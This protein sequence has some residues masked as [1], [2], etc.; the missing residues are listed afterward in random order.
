[1]DVLCHLTSVGVFGPI[2]DDNQVPVMDNMSQQSLP[3][4]NLL[5]LS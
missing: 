4:R 2:D 5:T 3:N 1:M